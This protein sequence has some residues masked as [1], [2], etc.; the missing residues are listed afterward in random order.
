[1]KK[2]FTVAVAMAISLSFAGC[3]GST[4][5]AEGA[6]AETVSETDDGSLITFENEVLAENDVVRI[7]LI[8]FYTE[9]VNGTDG[10]QN[11]KN[12]TVRTTNKSDKE[13][14][15][16]PSGFYINGE[17]MYVAMLSGPIAP[18]PGKS[19]NYNFRVAID[20]KPDHTALDSLEESVVGCRS[21]CGWCGLHRYLYRRQTEE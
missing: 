1:M 8:N 17:K 14:W 19:G 20:T 21:T 7:E 2:F 12:I 15:L 3:G 4:S 16:N 11:E 13:I 5:G 9:D 10:K 18:A 6:A